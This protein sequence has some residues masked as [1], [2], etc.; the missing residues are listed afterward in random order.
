[1]SVFA[2]SESVTASAAAWVVAGQLAAFLSLLLLASAAHKILRRERARRAAQDLCGM[3]RGAA[4]AIVAVLAA[5]EA[6][7]GVLLWLPDARAAGA[8]LA[9]SIWSTY[10]AVL[11]RAAATGR[12]DVDCGCSFGEMQHAPGHFHWMRALALTLLGAF[13]AL[14]SAHD[15]GAAAG[16]GALAT[17]FVAGFGMLAVY[18]ALDQLTALR[19]LRAGEVL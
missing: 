10:C 19:P 7:A 8:W 3:R 14:A 2:Y 13:V 9:A 12:S 4:G 17:Q 5:A 6:G 18:A 1:M 16:A 11:L 15:L